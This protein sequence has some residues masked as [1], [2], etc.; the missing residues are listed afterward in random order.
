MKLSLC[1][2]TLNEEQNLP[3]CLRS[4]RDVVDE[5]VVLDSGSTDATHLIASRFGA[6]VLHQDW[7]GHQGQKNKVIS[8]ATHDWVLLL[9]A[10]EEL[11][12][13]LQAEIAQIKQAGPPAGV[14]GYSMPRCVLYDGRWIRHGDWYPDRLVRLFNRQRGR[15]VGIEPHCYAAID[16]SDQVVR[17]S[18]DIFH[19]SFRDA[20]DHWDRAQKY[21]RIWAKT[22]YAVGRRANALSPWLHAGFRWL[23]TYLLRGG[24]L[25]GRQG[26]QIARITTR[27][28]FFKYQLLRNER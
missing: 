15:F 17:L 18:G 12:P 13:E 2:V 24:F 22:N 26:W 7:L 8:L 16:A 11:S 4:C 14:S 10:D 3:R 21:S 5:I 19:Y 23:R 20:A 28:V 9:D 6:R 27:E 25:D 1:V